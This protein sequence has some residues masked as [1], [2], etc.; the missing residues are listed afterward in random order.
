MNN[1]E[2]LEDSEVLWRRIHRT[3]V[4][5]NGQ[6]SSA[7]FSD[8]ELSVDISRIQLEMS[9]TLAGGAGVA[10]FQASTARALDQQTVADPL[11]DN[12]AHALVIGPKPKSVQRRLRDAASFTS[13][14]RILS[15]G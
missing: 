3:H 4:V 13:R 8:P 12:V 2:P 10:E 9:I 7:A 15:S 6:V 14:E 11:P 5:R 1:R